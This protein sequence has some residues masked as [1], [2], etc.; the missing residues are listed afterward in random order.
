M[1][2]PQPD[3]SPNLLAKP[4]GLAAVR[5]LNRKPLII[6]GILLACV[7]LAIGYG[8]GRQ[9]ASGQAAGP[10]CWHADAR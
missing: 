1:S 6:G 7:I 8:L 4:G 9:G 5:R 3:A 2:E 10:T